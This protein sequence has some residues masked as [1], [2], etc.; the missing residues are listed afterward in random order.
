[1]NQRSDRFDATRPRWVDD[2][3]RFACRGNDVI[4]SLRVSGVFHFDDIKA[5][6]SALHGAFGIRSQRQEQTVVLL[7]ANAHGAEASRAFESR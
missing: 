6:T 7:P 2:A 5:F 3:V 4:D 1:M